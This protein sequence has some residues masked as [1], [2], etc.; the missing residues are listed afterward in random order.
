M[1]ALFG[2]PDVKEMWYCAEVL[3]SVPNDGLCKAD[4]VK[5]RF[6]GVSITSCQRYCIE[7]HIWVRESQMPEYLAARLVE[8]TA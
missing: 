6:H 4:T 2:V 8:G 7:D 1:N 5:C 3:K